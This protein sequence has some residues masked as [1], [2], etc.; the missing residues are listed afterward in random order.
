MGTR[1]WLWTTKNWKKLAVAGVVLCVMIAGGLIG[2]HIHQQRVAAVQLEYY[3]MMK[4]PNGQ[5]KIDK[6]MAFIDQHPKDDE[7]HLAE[8]WMGSYY[9][10]KGDAE[11][12]IS[13]YETV[14]GKVGRSPLYY[15]AVEAIVPIYIENG[16]GEEG[17]KLYLEASDKKANSNADLFKL[18]AA[19]VF[20]LIGQMAEAKGIYQKLIND[21]NI[22]PEIKMKAE[23]QIL[24]IS[25]SGK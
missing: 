6:V 24:W 18:K 20:E 2:S 14:L 17:A 13:T 16:K 5:D 7:A 9:Q 21:E 15:L 22:S 23:E 12:A 1:L 25:A 19:S 8:M 11:K 10:G 3:E 4:M